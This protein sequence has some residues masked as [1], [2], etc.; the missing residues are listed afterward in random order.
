MSL[1]ACHDRGCTGMAGHKLRRSGARLAF[2]HRKAHEPATN[3]L[4]C[5]RPLKIKLGRHVE[6][7]KRQRLCRTA[8][9]CGGSQKA[10]SG[11]V[12][13]CPEIDRSR[14]ARTTCCTRSDRCRQTSASRRPRSIKEGGTRACSDGSGGTGGGCRS[15]RTGRG[16][17]PASRYQR[18]NLSGCRR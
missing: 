13:V 8:E 14:D 6:T 15:R 16:R 3:A 12:C 1:S 10:A 7:Q 11:E 5:S 9:F 17:S 2:F 18:S 4:L